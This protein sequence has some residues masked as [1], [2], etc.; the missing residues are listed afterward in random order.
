MFRSFSTFL[1][2]FARLPCIFLLSEEHPR[3][4]R[5]SIRVYGSDRVLN[6]ASRNFPTSQI[7]L[8]RSMDFSRTNSHRRISS[9]NSL[10]FF[11]RPFDIFRVIRN[12]EG[13]FFDDTLFHPLEGGQSGAGRHYVAIVRHGNWVTIRREEWSFCAP[14]STPGWDS[15]MHVSLTRYKTVVPQLCNR[16]RNFIGRG[17][18]LLTRA[19]SRD[20][21]HSLSLWRADQ[22]LTA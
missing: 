4:I 6:F 19:A 20:W 15:W 2:K 13:R 16:G 10:R 17:R 1:G 7:R 18:P 5:L 12:K 21:Q 11:S 3:F 8:D 9:T 14:V 22:K